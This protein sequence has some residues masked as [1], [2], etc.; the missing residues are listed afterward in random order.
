MKNKKGFTLVELLAVIVVLA[1]ILVIAVPRILET[2][3]QSKIGAIQS[4]T[5]LIAKTAEQKQLENESIGNTNTISCTG[6]A[7]YNTED[8]GSCNITFNNNIATVTLKGKTGGRFEGLTCTGTKD[9]VTCTE[10]ESSEPDWL[11]AFG[12]V[13]KKATS[14]EIDEDKCVEVLTDDEWDDVEA[15]C[16]GDMDT[17]DYTLAQ[18][19]EEEGTSW[20]EETGVIKNVVYG[21]NDGI[22]EDY[23]DLKDSNG[24]QRPVFIKFKSDL[25]EKYVCTMYDSTKADGF[26]TEPHCLLSANAY[27]TRNE[28]GSQWNQVETLFGASNCDEDSSD[29]HCYVNLSSSYWSC[30]AYSDG[31]VSCSWL[32]DRVRAICPVYGDGRAGCI[33]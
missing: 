23:R 21:W 27:S 9:N 24:K 11:Y 26:G 13:G 6:V 4:S 1:I 19:I 5:K 15:L 32:A 33:E 7:E 8:Y 18:Y 20:Y 12:V 29:V 10:S 22:E 17:Y 14:Y 25:S 16:S 31:L 28:T 3:K 2:I 30:Y